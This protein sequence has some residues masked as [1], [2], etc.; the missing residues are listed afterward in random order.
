MARFYT[1]I[2][3]IAMRKDISLP[4]K[5]YGNISP[6]PTVKEVTIPNHRLMKKFLKSN[7]GFWYSNSHIE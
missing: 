2:P 4:I 5:E 1:K 6:Y 3:P 7:Y